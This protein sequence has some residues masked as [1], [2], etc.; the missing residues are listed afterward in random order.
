[1]KVALPEI[2]NGNWNGFFLLR[3]TTHYR[4]CVSFISLWFILMSTLLDDLNTFL[5][6]ISVSSRLKE[7]LTLNLGQ[8]MAKGEWLSGI[9]LCYGLE[10]RGV[11]VPAGAGNFSLH[12]RVQTDSGAHPASYPTVTGGSFSRGKAA[13][14]ETD[15]S[16]PSGAEVKNAWSCT[17]TSTIRLHGVVLSFKKE[18]GQLYLLLISRKY[19]H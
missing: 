6:H 8:Y 5:V 13:G 17:S 12:H 1:M 14:R 7:E 11:R 16:P 19:S 18:Q 3:F 9:A 10:D 4:T 2:N 15:H